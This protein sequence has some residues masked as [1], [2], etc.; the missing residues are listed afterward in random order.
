MKLTNTW[1]HALVGA[2]FGLLWFLICLIPGMWQ[3]EIF[4][5]FVFLLG[6]IAWENTQIRNRRK[7]C[8]ENNRIFTWNW[9]DSLVDII[10]GNAGFFLGYNVMLRLTAGNWIV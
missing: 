5:M 4:G 9:L 1:K 8:K 7:Y 6:T 2:V 10:A 3:L